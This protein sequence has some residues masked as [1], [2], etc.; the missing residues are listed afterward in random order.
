[1]TFLDR[2]F[3]FGVESALRLND[4]AKLAIHLDGVVPPTMRCFGQLPAAVK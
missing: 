3:E 2:R 4:N 1:M